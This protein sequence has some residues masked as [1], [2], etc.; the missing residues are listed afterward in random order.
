MST[1]PA[2]ATAVD[3][4]PT[5]RGERPDRDQRVHPERHADRERGDS[6]VERHEAGRRGTPE[7][8]PLA[9]V[10]QRVARA[11]RRDAGGWPTRR[12]RARP[13]RR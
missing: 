6:D 4:N 10:G 2:S 1:A 8:R 12:P 11:D 3:T 7:E 13:S 5:G 9:A